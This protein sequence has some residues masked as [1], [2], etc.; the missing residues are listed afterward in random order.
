MH[1]SPNWG[2]LCIP[3]PPLK[4]QMQKDGRHQV[5]G[6]VA[7]PTHLNRLRHPCSH[8]AK[9]RIQMLIINWVRMQCPF[10]SV[11]TVSFG[12]KK[13]LLCLL[14]LPHPNLLAVFKVLKW[15][16]NIT[17]RT[18]LPKPRTIEFLHLL[19]FLITSVLYSN[20]THFPPNSKDTWEFVPSPFLLLCKDV[21]VFFNFAQ[22]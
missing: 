11:S 8:M 18:V 10:Q 5:T 4:R 13:S 12:L 7:D 15:P 6:Q 21:F 22:S 2:D 1:N 16:V 3:G 9:K 20:I 19:V 17:N 14:M